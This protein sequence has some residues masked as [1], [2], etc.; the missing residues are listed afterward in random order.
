VT[1]PGLTSGINAALLA[2]APAEASPGSG[3]GTASPTGAPAGAP[4]PKASAP[5]G[6]LSLLRDHIAVS[7]NQL[8][9]VKLGCGGAAPCR[10]KVTL[11]TRRA[12]TVRGHKRFVDVVIGTSGVLSIGASKTL[13]AK[14]ALNRIGRRMLRAAGGV[15]RAELTLV[16]AGHR[17]QVRVVLR[18]HR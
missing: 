3:S 4:L 18:A 8:A 6:T 7:A 1:A 13:T 12:V 17:Q 14:V 15:L 5:E 16:T 2:E 9:R 11:R 10:A